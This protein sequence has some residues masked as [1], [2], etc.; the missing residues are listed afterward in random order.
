MMPEMNGWEVINRLREKN[1][2]NKIPVV[3][4]TAK[5][6][7]FTKTF[8]NTISNDFIEKPFEIE[9]LRKRVKSVIKKANQKYPELI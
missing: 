1:E 4:L 8:G 7:E 2:W 5:T 3:F 6:D 9:D